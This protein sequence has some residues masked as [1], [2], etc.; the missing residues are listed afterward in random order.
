MP[1]ERLMT[2][3]RKATSRSVSAQRGVDRWRAACEGV[4]ANLP[5]H[6]IPLWD[7]RK[8]LGTGSVDQ[9]TEAFLQY[10]HDHESEAMVALEESAEKKLEAM[11]REYEARDLE[12]SD[13]P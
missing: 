7:K 5:P 12:T 4:A 1:G 3:F 10:A 13:G 11:I 8:M 6:L 2:R 9:R